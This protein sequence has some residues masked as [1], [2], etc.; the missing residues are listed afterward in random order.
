MLL[1][2]RRPAA[3]VGRV[4]LAAVAVV[5]ELGLARALLLAQRLEPLARAEAGVGGAARHE[6]T[7]VVAVDRG[8]LALAVGRVRAADVRPLVPRQAEPA[9]RLEDL[10]LARRVAALAVGVLDPEHEL[11]AVLLRDRV[12]EQRD[13]GGADVRVTGRARRDP[14][15][16]RHRAWAHSVRPVTVRF[17]LDE[18][19]AFA[20]SFSRFR[21]LA[22][23][24]TAPTASL[25]RGDLQLGCGRP[26]AKRITARR[27]G[28]C[29]WRRG[30]DSNPRSRLTPDNC[31][32]GSPDRP[33]QHL[34]A[35]GTVLYVRARGL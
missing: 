20:S 16:S 18:P 15:S 21:A 31:L 28:G 22:R 27:A 33:L 10:S 19:A 9:Q 3:G 12:V 35:P 17:H 13:V 26:A 32:A 24:P 7:R 23:N 29:D 1:A 14:V 6:L 34:S 8:A 11:A 2:G 30:R 4:E 25:E 5:A